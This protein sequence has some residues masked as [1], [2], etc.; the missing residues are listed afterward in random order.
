MS[1]SK[2][3]LTTLVSAARDGE[4]VLKALRLRSVSSA[5]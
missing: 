4:P 3:S 5:G 2:L 1:E